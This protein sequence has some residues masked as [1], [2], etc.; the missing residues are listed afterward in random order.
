VPEQTPTRWQEKA[1]K[2]WPRAIIHGC[3][4]FA[5]APMDGVNIHLFDD[6]F[7][8]MDFMDGYPVGRIYDLTEPARKPKVEHVI[9]FR[10][11]MDTEKD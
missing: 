11:K 1:Q 2:R 7:E 6:Y 3:G 4:Q 9:T 5:V 10:H 8:A